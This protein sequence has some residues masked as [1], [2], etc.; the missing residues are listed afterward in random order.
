MEQ[1]APGQA[2]GGHATMG[3]LF[4]LTS[5]SSRQDPGVCAGMSPAD[6][7]DGRAEG[8]EGPSPERGWGEGARAWMHAELGGLGPRGGLT[9]PPPRSGQTEPGSPARWAGL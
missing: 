9:L 3:L 5:I 8:G 1:V 4:P 7:P 6:L 2:G